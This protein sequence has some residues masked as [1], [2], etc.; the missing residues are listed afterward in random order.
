MPLFAL[1]GLRYTFAGYASFWY[2]CDLTNAA[3]A[4]WLLFY[5]RTAGYGDIFCKSILLN[6]LYGRK[7]VTI[8]CF[9]LISCRFYL[10]IYYTIVINTVCM[11]RTTPV[12]LSRSNKTPLFW[13]HLFFSKLVED[14]DAGPSLFYL[15]TVWFL[16]DCVCKFQVVFREL[17][18]YIVS[19]ALEKM[20]QV[21]LELADAL[22]SS[23]ASDKSRSTA[24]SVTSLMQAVCVQYLFDLWFLQTFMSWRNSTR[25]RQLENLISLNC[26]DQWGICSRLTVYVLY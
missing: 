10:F 1:A 18:T 17:H 15:I 3:L 9:F 23:T 11:G 12:F 25:V 8:N 16:F 4:P 20:L 19:S 26:S 6:A 14:F 22:L 7:P 24:A 13:F 21:Y 5:T 2:Y